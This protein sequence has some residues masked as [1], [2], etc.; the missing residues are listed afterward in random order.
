[1]EPGVVDD[2]G[3]GVDIDEEAYVKRIMEDEYHDD[4]ENEYGGEDEYDSEQERLELKI[5]LEEEI[6]R[7]EATASSATAERGANSEEFMNGLIDD[8]PTS[9]SI[10]D[11]IY[12]K[13]VERVEQRKMQSGPD[14]QT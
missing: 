9:L 13:A 5:S 2:H 7:E 4:D 1:M 11:F 6:M 14:K 12:Q 10:D 3:E 8:D